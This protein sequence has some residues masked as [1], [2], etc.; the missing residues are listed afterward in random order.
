M[1][2]H[3]FSQRV[4][5]S[6]HSARCPRHSAFG[7]LLCKAIVAFQQGL[8]LAVVRD[9]LEEFAILGSG[10]GLV[11]MLH[12]LANGGVVGVPEDRFKVLVGHQHFGLVARELLHT[13]D[14]V[15]GDT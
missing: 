12:V 8:L 3:L 9:P 6:L 5:E 2:N 10:Q 11:R 7:L 1:R 4:D 15:L 13:F 14:E